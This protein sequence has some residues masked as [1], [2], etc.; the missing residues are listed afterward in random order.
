MLLPLV[1]LAFLSVTGGW[2]GIPEALGGSDWFAPFPRPGHARHRRSS[3]VRTG[4]DRHAHRRPIPTTEPPTKPEDPQTE[5][6]LTGCSCSRSCSAGSL[7]TLSTPQAGAPASW[8]PARDPLWTRGQQILGRRDLRMPR[9]TPDT[10]HLPLHPVGGRSTAAWSTVGIA[11]AGATRDS[12]RCCAAFNPAI[13]VLMRAGSPSALPPFCCFLSSDSAHTS[14]WGSAR[15]MHLCI[16][17]SDLDA[18]HPSARRRRGRRGVACR[19]AASDPVVDF[20]CLAR[21]LR[22]RAAP[23]RLIS[24]TTAGL[25]V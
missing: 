25:P 23:A 8:P 22:A 19:A 2:I 15:T 11:A 21:N 18:D 3:I 4:L 7:P 24:S 13:S 14:T 9:R 6:V 5:R 17:H 12:A 20:A 16:D 10:G 1:L